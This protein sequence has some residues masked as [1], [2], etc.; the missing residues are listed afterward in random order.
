MATRTAERDLSHNPARIDK[1]RVHDAATPSSGSPLA[2]FGREN[3]A[4]A[5]FEASVSVIARAE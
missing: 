1:A 5:R 4:P 3:L 2:N